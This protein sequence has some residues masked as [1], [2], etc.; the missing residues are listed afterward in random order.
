MSM[1]YLRIKKTELSEIVSNTIESHTFF[2]TRHA[3]LCGV[4]R[5][6]CMVSRGVLGGTIRKTVSSKKRFWRTAAQVQG[7]IRS[8]GQIRLLIPDGFR[9][10]W[11]QTAST[12]LGR[13]EGRGWRWRKQ[14]REAVVCEKEMPSPFIFFFFWK[15]SLAWGVGSHLTCHVIFYKK[16][17]LQASSFR[18]YLPSS[19]DG[20]LLGHSVGMWQARSTR[21]ERWKM[22]TWIWGGYA[23]IL[24]S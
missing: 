13:V 20:N 21:E 9:H 15:L 10:F 17:N 4:G 7:N 22:R 12:S 8:G 24:S 11:R 19:G 14:K 2:D 5:D 1:F 23:R 3:R 18:K 6:G 16:S